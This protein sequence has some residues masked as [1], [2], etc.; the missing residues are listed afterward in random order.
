MSPVSEVVQLAKDAEAKIDQSFNA[1]DVLPFATRALEII[2]EH[3]ELRASFEVEFM[4]MSSYAATE[5][6][7]VCM[8]ALMWPTVKAEFERRYR[9]AVARNDW[10]SEPIYRHYL[11][12]FD[13]N[14]ED[15]SDFYAEYFRR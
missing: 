6:V 8:H 10:N 15:A 5:F 4:N 12:A 3:P 13:P 2:A 14:W 11:E 7:E 1:P 9:D